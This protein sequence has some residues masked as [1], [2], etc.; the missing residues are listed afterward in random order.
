MNAGLGDLMGLLGEMGRDGTSY[1]LAVAGIDFYRRNCWDSPVKV[2]GKD[3][4]LADNN[5]MSRVGLA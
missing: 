1:G 2:C 5:A 3:R 4:T